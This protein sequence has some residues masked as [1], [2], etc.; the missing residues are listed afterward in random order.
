MSFQPFLCHPCTPI[1]IDL[2]FDT[3]TGILNSAVF[4]IQDPLKLPQTVFPTRAQQVGDHTDVVQEEPLD[5]QC[6]TKILATCV[7][8]DVSKYLDI[9][10]LE[11]SIILGG[12]PF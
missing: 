5:L 6:S 1:K 8:E 4:P 2:A 12:P 7:L 10:T 3:Q 9:L 11:V